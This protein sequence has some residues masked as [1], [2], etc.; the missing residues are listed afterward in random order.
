MTLW[1]IIAYDLWNFQYTYANLPTHTWYC[2]VALL[3]AP[4]FAAA[5][6]NKGGWIQNRANTLALWCMFAQ[7]VPLFQVQGKFSVLPSLYKGAQGLDA[8]A[9]SNIAP[10]ANAAENAAILAQHG[11]TA[12]PKAQ[13]VVA[14]LSLIAN[15]LVLT[16]IIKRSIKLKKNPYKGEIWVGTKDFTEAMERAEA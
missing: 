11:I 7:V 10:G 9:L 14:M 8:M 6:W 5:F 4:T 13:G 1:F 12:D 15:V 16:A 2:G 3:L